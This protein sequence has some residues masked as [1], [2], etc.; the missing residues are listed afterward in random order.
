MFTCY[1]DDAGGEDHGFVSVAGWLAT[2]E[3]WRFFEQKWNEMLAV[4]RI[5]YFTMK[6]CAQFKGPFEKWKTE[7]K[8]RAKFLQTACQIIKIIS[9]QGF[10]VIVP[11]A[12]YREVNKDFALKEVT[13]SE[14]ALAGFSSAQHARNWAAQH[15][16]RVPIEF[17]YHKG[18]KG[19]G[20]LTD[21]MISDLRHTPIFRPRACSH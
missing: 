8:T 15:Y 12:A 14:Y 2:L 16:P 20:G 7:P 6:E 4:Y 10:G 19:H 5:P 11:H 9:L 3:S 17:V 21:L 18:T 13:K 1:F